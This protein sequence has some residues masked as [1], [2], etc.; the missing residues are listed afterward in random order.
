V[1]RRLLRGGGDEGCAA[2]ICGF[3]LGAIFAGLLS[4][5]CQQH[6]PSMAWRIYQDAKIDEAA[7]LAKSKLWGDR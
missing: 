4:M 3:F 5:N 6:D 2:V 7:N 1:K